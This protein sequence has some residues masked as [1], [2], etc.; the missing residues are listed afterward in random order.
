VTDLL[1]AI[2]GHPAAYGVYLKDEP[3]ADLFAGLGA[4]AGAIREAAPALWPY[5][6]LFPD[7]ATTEQLGVSS[8]AD[9]L[10]RFIAV[11]RPSFISYDNYS[12]M[13]DGDLRPAFWT[14]LES[15]REAACRHRIPF[16]NI[17]LTT[18]HFNYR[19]VSDADM[20]LQ[21]YATLAYGGRG[22]SGFTYFTPHVGN[23][24]GGP[25]DQFGHRTPAWYAV[26]NAN[27]QLTQL[28][29]TINRLTSDRVYHLGEIPGGGKPPDHESLIVGPVDAPFLVGE[30]THE[31]GSRYAMVV[32]RN[33]Y[34]S[35]YLSPVFRAG[36]QAAGMVSPYTGRTIEFAGE[37][38]WLA[39]G[40]GALLKVGVVG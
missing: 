10:E 7:Y 6:N 12:L 25:I 16:Q 30:F 37:Q 39:P 2:G 38:M 31:D 9:Y 17:V 26:R 23:Y 15:V 33:V 27:L 20:R 11:C 8:Y 34:R 32:N 19:E 5:I 13:D 40:Q 24:R 14:N 18:A 28:A 3:S 36:F 1:K 21:Y 22:V 29:P 35:H 4:V